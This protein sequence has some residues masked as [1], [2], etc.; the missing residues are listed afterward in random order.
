MENLPLYIGNRWKIF[1]LSTLL[2]SYLDVYMIN[3]KKTIFILLVISLAGACA[4]IIKD[5]DNF[6]AKSNG[7]KKIIVR[8]FKSNLPIFEVE[9]PTE[10]KKIYSYLYFSPTDFGSIGGYSLDFIF[11]D[12]SKSLITLGNSSWCLS[13][14]QCY[15]LN[16]E[17]FTF[18]ENKWKK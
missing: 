9:D 4:H 16:K 6:Q 10:I 2:F 15:D 14:D 1:H 11:E 3:F 17:I 13:M 18:I 5:L 12:G 7:C 8:N